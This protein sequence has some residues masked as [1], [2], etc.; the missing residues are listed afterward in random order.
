VSRSIAHHVQKSLAI[1][2]VRP[3]IDGSLVIASSNTAAE[4]VPGRSGDSN[5]RSRRSQ[6]AAIRLQ[7]VT[8]KQSHRFAIRRV[9]VVTGILYAMSS[10]H[11]GTSNHDETDGPPPKR[12]RRP[13]PAR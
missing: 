2:F 10:N 7:P 13:D 8:I 5:T 3:E 1:A 4:P 9:T 11:G 6:R 12:S